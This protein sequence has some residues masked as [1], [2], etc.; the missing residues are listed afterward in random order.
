MKFVFSTNITKSVPSRARGFTLRPRVFSTRQGGFTLIELMI[1]IAILIIMTT[2]MLIRQRQIDSIV[3]VRNVAT[4]IA[5]MVRQAQ[6]YGINRRTEDSSN[7]FASTTYGV[8]FDISNNQEIILFKDKNGDKLYSSGEMV[9]EESQK[10]PN[11]V[12]IKNIYCVNSGSSRVTKNK[13]HISFTRPFPD[14]ELVFVPGCGTGVKE[15][16]I[17]IGDTSGDPKI[18]DWEFTISPSGRITKPVVVPTP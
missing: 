4:E 15:A 11:K 8:Y 3:R 13:L 10:L 2:T 6:V 9:N 7:A 17:R 5:Q 16:V 12:E 14:A 18:S 1:S